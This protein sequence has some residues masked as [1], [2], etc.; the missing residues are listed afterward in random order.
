MKI[1]FGPISIDNFVD[2]T[3]DFF[4]CGPSKPIFIKPSAMEAELSLFFIFKNISAISFFYKMVVIE[5]LIL[6]H[7]FLQFS[8][9]K[10]IKKVFYYFDC[11]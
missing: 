7:F 6:G 8:V 9:K 11:D 2:S 4:E 1:V 10:S 3:I 5:K